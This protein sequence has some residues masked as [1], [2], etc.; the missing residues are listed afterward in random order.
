M[1]HMAVLSADEPR[2]RSA[3]LMC[4]Y[5]AMSQA[6]ASSFGVEFKTAL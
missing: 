6:L 3:M 5:I 2:E 1:I 4:C